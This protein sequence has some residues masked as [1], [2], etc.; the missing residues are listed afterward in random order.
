MID[1]VLWYTGLM[2]W[3]LVACAG[4][5]ILAADVHDQSV[6]RHPPD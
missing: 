5:T 4:T 2:T 3:F 1:A 6:R